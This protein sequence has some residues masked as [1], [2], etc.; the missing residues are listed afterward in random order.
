M[1]GEEIEML[2]VESV[3]ELTIS[4]INSRQGIPH[5]PINHTGIVSF[6]IKNYWKQLARISVYIP[7]SENYSFPP[8]TI[9]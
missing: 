4:Y 3:S 2:F 9:R 5:V 8:P 6:N 7:S 1:M